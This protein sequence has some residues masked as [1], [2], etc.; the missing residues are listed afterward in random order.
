[1]PGVGKDECRRYLLWGKCQH[2][3][4]C[5]WKHKTAKDAQLDVAIIKLEKFINNP[6]ELKGVSG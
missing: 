2:G 3:K 5:K 1:M 4:K 6:E